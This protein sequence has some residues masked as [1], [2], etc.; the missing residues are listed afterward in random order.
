MTS[1]AAS[2]L[3]VV[4][5]AT[6][7][8]SASFKRLE[9]VHRLKDEITNWRES[10]EWQRKE[11]EATRIELARLRDERI[12]DR[13]DGEGL[14]VTYRGEELLIS[15]GHCQHCRHDL[16]FVVGEPPVRCAYCGR[17]FASYVLQ[18]V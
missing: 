1:L 18:E 8:F 11:L 16:F 12:L 4:I 17:A 5:F 6:S 13:E 15:G 7:S 3:I 14:R 10:G 9:A 2:F